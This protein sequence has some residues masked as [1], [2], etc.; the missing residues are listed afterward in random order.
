MSYTKQIWATGDTVTAAKLNHMEV[1][2]AEAGGGSSGGGV[3]VVTITWD[4]NSATMDKTWQEIHDAAVSGTPIIV[5]EDTGNSITFY[6]ATGIDYAE[7]LSYVF[8]IYDLIGA[9]GMDFEASTASGYPSY[10]A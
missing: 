10:T 3:L 4:D 8:T 1:G 2:I 5:M 9:S 7:G 6:E